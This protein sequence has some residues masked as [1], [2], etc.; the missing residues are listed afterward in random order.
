MPLHSIEM[1]RRWITETVIKLYRSYEYIY[2]LSPINYLCARGEKD[3]HTTREGTQGFFVKLRYRY[4]III[5]GTIYVVSF[6]YI[7]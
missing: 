3:I 7:K 2:I 6:E 4:I 1:I 5:I